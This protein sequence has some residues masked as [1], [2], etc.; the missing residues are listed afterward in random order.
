[1]STMKTP[2][3][4]PVN[5]IV[6]I[7]LVNLKRACAYMDPWTPVHTLPR[8]QTSKCMPCSS[9]GLPLKKDG[10]IPTQSGHIS[11]KD[12]FN[13]QSFNASQ[14]AD[15]CRFFDG[16]TD[17]CCDLTNST[18]PYKCAQNIRNEILNDDLKFVPPKVQF[19]KPV[20]EY[21]VSY[22]MLHDINIK[23]STASIFVDIGL[24]WKDPRLAWD[25]SPDFCQTQ[26]KVK[27]SE[28]PETTEIWV[29]DFNLI[30]R[31]MGLESWNEVMAF[32]NFDGTVTWIR[33]G[34]LEA[35][36]SFQ[37]MGQ[38]PFDNL[39]CQFMFGSKDL[40]YT[41]DLVANTS[42]EK[43]TFSQKYKEFDL[44]F[45]KTRVFHPGEFGGAKKMLVYNFYFGRNTKFYITK[46]IV[47][48]IL[49]T[50]ISFG[51][52]L[53]DLRMGERL[54]Y[55]ISTVVVIVAQE[56]ITNEH[57]PISDENLWLN[58]FIQISTYF[59]Y[60]ALLESVIVSWI[61]F[62]FESEEPIETNPRNNLTND[63]GSQQEL[64]L[65]ENSPFENNK[66]HQSNTSDD[67][68]LEKSKTKN[69]PED[70]K[71]YDFFLNIRS[72]GQAKNLVR[73]IDSICVVTFPLCYTIFL[74]V[75]FTAG[76]K[77]MN[78]ENSSWLVGGETVYGEL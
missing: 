7:I 46:I 34:M 16:L 19:K 63:T 27:A 17:L 60:G 39:G 74:I 9:I 37:G 29:P 36:C 14:T 77:I 1:M 62:K 72:D 26:I 24:K 20:V 12:Y 75:I 52:F 55:G 15:F 73:K 33:S 8:Y 76:I 11:C 25:I 70:D 68:C 6:L 2:Y 65:C 5:V 51:L 54:G 28:S 53:L 66:T 57:I 58:L 41:Y 38:I 23:E 32:V 67:A 30:N 50:Y 56:I 45:N 13:L 35:F 21:R 64:A 31:A 59:T 4:N 78:D 69:L 40:E 22:E 71:Q 10:F 49:F 61:Y 3:L 18:E 42:F 44:I 48:T 47:P 43:G